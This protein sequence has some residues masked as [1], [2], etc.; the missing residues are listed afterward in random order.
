MKRPVAAFSVWVQPSWIVWPPQ[1]GTL[2]RLLKLA[3]FQAIVR[4]V[5]QADP[6]YLRTQREWFE[7]AKRELGA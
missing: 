3:L 1:Q 6:A 5:A 2:S 4:S 7:I